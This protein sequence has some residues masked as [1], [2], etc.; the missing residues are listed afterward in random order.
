MRLS[1]TTIGEF[2]REV[3]RTVEVE[4]TVRKNVNPLSLEVRRS[5]DNAN[6]TGLHEVVRDEEVL[7][8]WR[9]LDVVWAYD[10]LVLVWVI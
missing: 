2:H 8:V 1:T 3:Y 5:V 6:V 4:T 10:P 9:H 7:L